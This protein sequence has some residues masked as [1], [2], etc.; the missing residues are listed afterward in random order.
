MTVIEGI[1]TSVPLHLKIL[2]DP[3]FIAGRLNTAFMD[4][5][6]PKAKSDESGG[7]GKALGH[8][9]PLH[10]IVDV[11]VAGARPAG[12]SRVWPAHI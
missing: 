3:D 10:A 2:K 11:D 5:F 4:R 6:M 9:F 1:K 12:M 8:Q 7:G